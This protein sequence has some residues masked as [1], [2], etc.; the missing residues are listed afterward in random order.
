[1]KRHHLGIVLGLLL[2]F[3]LRSTAQTNT[4]PPDFYV[5]SSVDWANYFP[6][7]TP[8]VVIS[9]WTFECRSGLQPTTQRQGTVGIAY[10]PINNATPVLPNFKVE[11]LQRTDVAAAFTASCPALGPSVGFWITAT[12]PPPGKYVVF[13]SWLTWDGAGRLA[14]HVANTFLTVPN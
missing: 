5:L 13:V 11:T 4:A 1:M 10:Y 9:G 3:P 2:L 8:V 12:P 14:Q 7:P 6:T